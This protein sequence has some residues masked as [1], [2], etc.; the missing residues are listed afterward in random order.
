M[1]KTNRSENSQVARAAGIVGAATMVSRVFG[2]ARDMVIAAFFGASWMTDAFW[3]AFRIPNMLRR[4][5]GEGSLTVSFVPVFT[6]YLEKKT[7]EQALELA[8]NAITLLSIILAVIS[9][10]GIILSPLIVGL[11]A[12]GFISEPKQFA[13]AV[14]LNRLMFPYIFFIA[15]VALCMGILNSFRHFTAPALSPVLL[16]IAMIGAAF[17]LRPFFAEPITSLA[18]GVLIG[19]VLQLAMQWPFLRKF[20]VKLKFRFNPKHPGIKQIGVLMIPAI[21]GAGVSTINVF[22]GTILASL[23]PGG[24]VTYLFYADRIMEL[25]LGIFAIAIG[26]ATL[27]SFSKHVAAGNMDELK[28]GISFSLRLML[29]LTIPAMAALMA[30][31]LPIISVLFQRGAFDVTSAVYTG[32][33]LFCYALGLWAFSVLRVFVSSF[34]SLQDSKWPMKA[35]VIAL[36]VNVVASLILMYPLKHNGIALASSIAATV[37]VLVLTIVL[38]RKIGKFLDRAFYYSVFKI[39]LSSVLMLFAIGVME[40]VIPWNTHAGFKARLLYL[41]V[42]VTAGAATFFISAYLLKSPEMQ[43]FANIVKKRLSRP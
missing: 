27:P 42:A 1:T 37:N 25:P 16:N 15:L 38:K 13:L 17:F 40:Y 2:L 29:F 20:G 12:P 5:L 36:I 26:T 24:S 8:Y 32:Q 7:K 33:A 10:L 18:I 39:I 23:L 41:S 28:S 6:E 22:V 43:A 3:V 14:F 31:N 21:L 34:Y 19:G 35:A 4:L 9:V 11:I 30:L